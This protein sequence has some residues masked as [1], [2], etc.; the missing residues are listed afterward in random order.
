MLQLAGKVENHEAGAAMMRAAIESGAGLEKLKEMIRAQGGDPLVCDDVTRLPQAKVIRR[1]VC[2]KAGCVQKMDATALGL[3][4]QAMG[5]GRMKLDDELDYAV[6][7]VL[8]VRIGDLVRDDTP[9]CTLYA[10]SEA[11]AER[12]EQAV[13]AAISIGDEPCGRAP[14]FLAI[15]T[16]DGV[17]R[18]G[19]K[20]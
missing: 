10:R 19:E 2:G 15:V 7:F 11:D 8:N 1:V 4:A 13:R 14:L 20:Q 6:G 16:K 18:L 5:A 9:L 3:A 17:E 12:A